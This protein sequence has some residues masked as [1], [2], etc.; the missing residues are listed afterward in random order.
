MKDLGDK[1]KEFFP[2]VT[3]AMV[4][5]LIWLVAKS[6]GRIFTDEKT[7]YKTETTIEDLDPIKLYGEY[8]IDSIEE[9]ETKA[10]RLEQRKLDSSYQTSIK[11]I[12][13]LLRL[14]V[15]LSS[16]TKKNTERN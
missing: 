4:G 7:K 12:D 11:R 6:E 15:R 13:S 8:I 10:F 9:V 1:I 16:E 14:N 2:F 3:W 5:G